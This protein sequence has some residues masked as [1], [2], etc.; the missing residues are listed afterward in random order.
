MRRGLILVF[1]LLPGANYMYMGLIKRGL[2]A[3]CGFFLLIYL[4]TLVSG[5]IIGG[6]L[7]LLIALSMPVLVLTC[8]FDSFNIRRR[9]VN[10]EV[11]QDNIDDVIGFFQRN[12]KILLTVIIICIGLGV[13][14]SLISWLLRPLRHIIPWLII[15]FGAYVI[16][17]RKAKPQAHE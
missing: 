15:G 1:S 11:V 16:F 7:T 6:P 3:M 10:G 14:G 9:I 2:A 4:L 12:K 13:V 8:A 17:R 5:S